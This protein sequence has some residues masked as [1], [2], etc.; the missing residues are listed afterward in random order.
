MRDRAMQALYLLALEPIAE[1]RGDENSYGFRRCRSTADAIAQCFNILSPQRAATWILEGDIHAC[2]DRISHE[3]MMAHIPMEKAILRTWLKA[4]YMERH[5]LHPTEH[6][7][8]QGGVASPVLANL[9]LDG[10]E[11][12]IHAAIPPSTRAGHRAKVNFV[13]YADD[14]IITGASR[15]LLEQ[16]IT[17]VVTTFLQE[18]GLTLSAD[19]TDVT[20]IST[21]FD[22]LGHTLRKYDGKLLITPSKDN[23]LAFLAKVRGIIQTHKQAPAASLIILLNPVLRGWANYYR[24]VVSKARYQAC[25]HAIFCALWRWAQRRHP[26]KGRRWVKEKYFCTQGKRRWV[27]FGEADGERHYLRK[28]SRTPIWRHIKVRAKANPFDPQWDYYFERR[29]ALTMEQSL[30]GQRQAFQLWKEQA[31]RCPVCQQLITEETGWHNHHV[32]WRCHGGKDTVDNRVLVHPQCHY[33]VHTQ[34][35]LVVKPRPRMG[36]Q[37]A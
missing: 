21:G 23:T 14:F 10:L 33:Q 17:P 12:A 22:F 11:Q 1:T 15:E 5:T 31:G 27:F 34:G 9:A 32:V 28:L 20:H 2:F 24:H 4:G 29:L 6:G 35:I 18:R 26:N 13:R 19:K 3:W 25:D 36:E 30:G 8:P 7:T 16:T 37:E